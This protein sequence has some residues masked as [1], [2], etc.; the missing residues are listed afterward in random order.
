[1]RPPA[2]REEHHF[3][4]LEPCFPEADRYN[5]KTRSVIP[6]EQAGLSSFPASQ[7]FR[8]FAPLS[9]YLSPMNCQLSAMNRHQ[10][11]RHA[12]GTGYPGG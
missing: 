6:P 11:D 2:P 10:G 7:P 1:M 9:F 5:L 3:L 8:F 4:P 12:A